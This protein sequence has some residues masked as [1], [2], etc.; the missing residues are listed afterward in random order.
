[1]FDMAVFVLRGLIP[2]EEVVWP[3][4]RTDKTWVMVLWSPM[5]LD[6]FPTTG[7]VLM[8]RGTECIEPGGGCMGGVFG[9]L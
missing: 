5:V 4:S 3:S 6:W 7:G 9:G 2:L 1:M 8:W